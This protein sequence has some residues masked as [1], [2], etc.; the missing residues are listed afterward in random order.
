MYKTYTNWENKE[1]I[2]KNDFE[3]IPADPA[4]SDYQ[5]YQVWLAEGNTPEEWNPNDNQ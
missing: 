1:F 2:V 5:A 3:W 4:N